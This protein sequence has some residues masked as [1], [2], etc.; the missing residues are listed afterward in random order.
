[1]A[2]QPVLKPQDLVVA[3]KLGT[4][5]DRNFTFSGLA[6]E[7]HMSVSE[8]HASVRRA[9]LSRLIVTDSGEMQADRMSLEEFVL[10]GVRYAFPAV[11]GPVA[12]GIPTAGAGPVLAKYYANSDEGS[13]VWPHPSGQTRGIALQPLYPTVPL[14]ALD[15]LR[16]YE[17]LTLVDAV[18]AG[19]ARDRELAEVEFRKRLL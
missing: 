1:M 6:K 4:N 2:K 9:Q 3:L 18:R 7:L 13:Y 5:S 16:L 12:R 17:A 10:R 11:M 8:A 15:D 19:T 14:A